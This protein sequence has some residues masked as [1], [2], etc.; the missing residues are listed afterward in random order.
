MAMGT[1]NELRAEI[2]IDADPGTVWAMLTTFEAYPVWNP[3]IRSIQGSLE[4]GSRLHVRLQ[5]PGGR[6][7]TMAP[8]VT[9]SEAGRAFGWLGRVGGIPR[10][11][12]GAHRFELES[13]DEGRRTRLV[14]S[15][16]F[17]GILVPFVQRSIL[18]ATL[19]GF[20][21]MNRALADR[22]VAAKASA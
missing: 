11:F 4:P 6:G 7:I 15:E 22:A 8:V 19:E 13:M 17:R 2:E 3:F 9:V 14:Q 5:P 18:P 20:E 16:R 10:L 21:A 12:D 1:R